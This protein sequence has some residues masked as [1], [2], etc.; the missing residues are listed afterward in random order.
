M[1]AVDFSHMTVSLSAMCSSFSP[2]SNFASGNM[3]TMWLCSVAGHN[4]RKVID[5]TTFVQIRTTWALACS[6][7]C[8]F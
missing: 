3:S 2:P 4:H 8:F 5:N 1:V 6:V 7:F